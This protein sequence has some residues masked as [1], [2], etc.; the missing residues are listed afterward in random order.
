[1]CRVRKIAYA[2][3]VV[4]EIQHATGRFKL[5]NFDSPAPVH[6]HK[7]RATELTR[8]TRPSRAGP[9]NLTEGVLE[10]GDFIGLLSDGVIYAGM[11]VS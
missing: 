6:L 7:G 4:L 3:F 1:M 2:T 9:W 8:R 10:R 11:G 5:V